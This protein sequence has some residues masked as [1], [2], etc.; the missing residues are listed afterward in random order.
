M[1]STLIISTVI[2]ELKRLV[3][4]QSSVNE[5]KI[6]SIELEISVTQLDVLKELNIS[7]AELQIFFIQLQTCFIIQYIFGIVTGD[8]KCQ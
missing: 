3:L 7:F 4:L 1:H 6:F 8:Y 5:L 2:I